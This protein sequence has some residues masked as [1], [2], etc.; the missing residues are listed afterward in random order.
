MSYIA[1]VAVEH[2][3]RRAALVAL[4]GRRRRLGE[5]AQ[6]DRLGDAA[7][8]AHPRDLVHGVAL[9]QLRLDVGVRAGEPAVAEAAD[10][11]REALAADHERRHHRASGDAVRAVGDRLRRRHRQAQEEVVARRQHLDR[12]VDAATDPRRRCRA[13][14]AAAPAR[15]ASWRRCCGCAARRRG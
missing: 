3:L 12:R 11:D 13:A 2:R 7:L 6:A 8:A 10:P 1:Q 9:E 4:Q 15:T 14:P 5:P